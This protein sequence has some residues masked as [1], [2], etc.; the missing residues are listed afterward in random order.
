MMVFVPHTTT[1][2]PSSECSSRFDPLLPK[3]CA[4]THG[5]AAQ[6]LQELGARDAIGI[7]G[8]IMRARDPQ[9]PTA[10]IVEHNNIS[11][12]TGQVH[13]RREAPGS[14]ADHDA[15]RSHALRAL[16]QAQEAPKC[17]SECTRQPSIRT[18]TWDASSPPR[19]R[20]P[21]V[22]DLS[23]ASAR[24]GNMP[25]RWSGRALAGARARSLAFR[26]ERHC[27]NRAT[28]RYQKTLR[29]RGPE[30]CVYQKTLRGRG[31][32]GRDED[33]QNAAR[34][35]PP[36]HQATRIL[37]LGEEGRPKGRAEEHWLR[38]ETEMAGVN[39]GGEAA[40]SG[41]PGTG[42]PTTTALP[43][44]SREHICPACAGTGRLGRNRCKI[45]RRH[46][47]PSTF[48]NRD[49]RDY[50]VARRHAE[51]WTQQAGSLRLPP[52]RPLLI[53]TSSE[54]QLKQCPRIAIPPAWWRAELLWPSRC[55]GDG[56]RT[57]DS[58][59]RPEAL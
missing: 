1:K 12:I 20:D 25:G 59:P 57:I 58:D 36:T 22:R 56:T 55:D 40:P 18:D 26:S 5:L 37:A 11:Q 54:E 48:P 10:A 21:R 41:T 35:S 53:S 32:E 44:R 6:P 14:G 7:A 17:W 38:A 39:T 29:G 19:H 2:L 50:S 46:P 13:R 4:V 30:V 8:A 34:G 43:I 51:S 23:V 27:T 9:R 28:V 31:P 45:M 16:L 42:A 47:P 52:T 49:L 15:V 24:P 33:K 3:R